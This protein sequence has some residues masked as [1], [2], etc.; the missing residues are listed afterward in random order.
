MMDWNQ[1]MEAMSKNWMDAQKKVWDNFFDTVEGLGKSQSTKMWESTLSVGE[2]MLKNMFKVQSDWV[3]AWVDGLA[4][5][6]GLPEAAIDS[7]KR[8]QEMTTHWNK[9]Q[10][11]LIVNWFEVLKKFAP[12]RPTETWAELM[13]QSM[14]KTWQDS[15]QS[16]MEAQVNWMRTWMGQTGKSDE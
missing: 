14:F 7:A 9:T 5:I 13:P 16:I 10:A 15:T 4:S 6:E 11:D 8:F 3:A 12:T 2:D 1:Q